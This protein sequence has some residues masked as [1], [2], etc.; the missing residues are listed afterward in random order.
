[1]K[2]LVSVRITPSSHITIALF[3]LCMAINPGGA[4]AVTNIDST[5]RFNPG[6]QILDPAGSAG[7]S[8]AA[9]APTII[10]MFT[11]DSARFISPKP[12]E[13]ITG[14]TAVCEIEPKM[15]VDSVKIFVRHSQNRLDTIGTASAPPY[16]AVWDCSNVPDQDGAH[17]QFGYALY[18]PDAIIVSPPTPHRWA[19]KREERMPSNRQYNIRQQARESEFPLD[20]DRAKWN[21][22]QTARIGD[23][24]EFAILWTS[25]KLYFAA[26]I[27][28]SSVTPGDFVELHLDMYRDR[29]DFTNITHRSL[30]FSPLTRSIAFVGEYVEGKGYVRNDSLTQLLRDDIDWKAAVD[31]NGKGYTIEAAIPLSLLSGFDLPQTKIGMDVAVMNIDRVTR[32]G[33]AANLFD[34]DEN[35]SDD[36]NNSGDNPPPTANTA[37]RAVAP[38]GAMIGRI[39]NDTAFYSWAGATQFTRYSPGTWGTAEFAQEATWLK[40]IFYMLIGLAAIFPIITIIQTFTTRRNEMRDEKIMDDD[41]YSPITEAVMECVEKGLANANFGLKDVLKSINET[42]TNVTAALQKDLDSSFDKLLTY[43]RIKRSQ[44]LMKDADISIEEIAEMCGFADV[45]KYK[46]LYAAQMMVD[47][48]ISRDAVLDRIREDLEAEEEDDDD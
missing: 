39:E 43:R 38:I 45:G 25:A 48:E 34:D 1:M 44:G 28:D 20:G 22:A 40:A 27:N 23:I 37:T 3:I 42:E 14:N 36:N 19:L 41:N 5:A 33:N 6:L 13:A 7:D 35:D 47:P 26:W 32:S 21:R 17:L 2:N 15:P 46:E 30:R 12:R 4:H 16:K 8:T 31:T 29:A 11:A 10:K 9:P 18:L 24:G